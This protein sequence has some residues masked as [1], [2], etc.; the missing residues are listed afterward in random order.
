MPSSL[1]GAGQCGRLLVKAIAV[2]FS[3]LTF[4]RQQEQY[5]YMRPR[6][7]DNRRATVSIRH[8]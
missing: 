5:L 4:N 2:F 8:D 1:I 3:I 7:R 6:A